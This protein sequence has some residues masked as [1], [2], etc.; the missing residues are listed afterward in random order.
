M[1]HLLFLLFMAVITLGASPLIL[2]LD[3]SY[4]SHLQGVAADET[5]LYFSFTDVLV[6]TDYKGKVLKEF[7]YVP[8]MGDLCIVDG[9]LFVA[10][11]FRSQPH[12]AANGNR[13]SAVLQISTDLE[14]K[15]IHPLDISRGVDGITFCNGKFYMAP[16]YGREPKIETGIMLFDRNFKLLKE[17]RFKTG[18]NIKFGAQTL[19][20]VKG[21]ILAAFYDDSKGAFIFE[22]ETWKIIG[23][24]DIKPATGFTPIPEKIAGRKNI[25]MIGGLK[26]KRG[27][28]KIYGRT[29]TLTDEF[30]TV[31]FSLPG[32]KN[33]NKQNNNIIK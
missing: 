1:K 30:K 26:G 31:N 9:D 27:D 23:Q 14:L 4:P 22:P 2:N 29:V 8:H 19:T 13:K 24:A 11:Q 15:K 33:N 21:G 20:T 6:K 10:T 16:D 32:N 17:I 25:Y 28:W 12:L 7:K 3:V 18:A 5:G